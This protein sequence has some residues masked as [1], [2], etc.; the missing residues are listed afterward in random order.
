MGLVGLEI[1]ADDYSQLAESATFP[2]QAYPKQDDEAPD[3]TGLY[4]AA[5]AIICGLAAIG[6]AWKKI[7]AG[8]NT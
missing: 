3:R 7:Y 4:I 1:I 6:I 5:G 8:S 2:A